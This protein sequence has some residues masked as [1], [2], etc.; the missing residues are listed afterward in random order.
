MWRDAVSSSEPL[1]KNRMRGIIAH[2]TDLI[3]TFGITR[4]NDRRLPS[5]QDDLPIFQTNL[6]GEV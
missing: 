3:T 2:D 5:L 6:T 1:H 4:M